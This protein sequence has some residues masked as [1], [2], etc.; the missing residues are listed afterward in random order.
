MVNKNNELNNN[1]ALNTYR[2]MGIFSQFEINEEIKNALSE[3]LSE[4]K[5]FN[6]FCNKYSKLHGKTKQVKKEFLLFSCID[7]QMKFNFN[8]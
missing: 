6:L 5:L 4:D 2:L 8:F 1:K 3:R 7:M